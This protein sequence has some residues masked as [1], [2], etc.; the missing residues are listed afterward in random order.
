MV[1]E[2]VRLYARREPDRKRAHRE[3]I[4]R[5]HRV[6]A[7]LLGRHVPKGPGDRAAPELAGD[8]F[9]H[10]T[11]IEEP[12]R[13]RRRFAD[14][15]LRFHVAVDH[16]RRE[17]VQVLEDRQEL[18]DQIENLRLGVAMLAQDL[19][20]VLPFDDSPARGRVARRVP[21]RLGSA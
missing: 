11:E 13:T 16:R 21:C 4:G 15:V 7:E 9:P 14:H 17:S 18:V 3:E 5:G 10:C 8:V 19:L 1:E 12:M 2:S 6:A 20:E